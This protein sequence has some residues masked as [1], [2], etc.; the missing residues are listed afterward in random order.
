MPSRDRSTRDV[1]TARDQGRQG[2]ALPALAAGGHGRERDQAGQDPE[3]ADHAVAD[4]VRE[5]S[6]QPSS[7]E[8]LMSR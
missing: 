6:G 8:G 3:L 7:T 4:K 2:V 1:R 5:D